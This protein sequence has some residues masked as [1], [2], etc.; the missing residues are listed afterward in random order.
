MWAG[1][2]CHARCW[3]GRTPPGR[4]QPRAASEQSPG[5]RR[6]SLLAAASPSM[7]APPSARIAS[8]V[9]TTRRRLELSGRAVDRLLLRDRSGRVVA[10]PRAIAVDGATSRRTVLSE[11]ESGRA[12]GATPR[13]ATAPMQYLC[14]ASD[15]RRLPALMLLVRC[16]R[17]P[18]ATGNAC[19]CLPSGGAAPC[20]PAPRRAALIRSKREWP[21]RGARASA[22]RA[23]RWRRRRFVR[24]RRQSAWTSR[25]G[26]WE[27]R[28]GALRRSGR[29]SSTHP[30]GGTVCVQR[31]E[32]RSLSRRQSD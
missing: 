23:G 30:E 27:T 8:P 32:R 19:C 13:G 26:L 6:A 2:R 17:V 29:Q 25:V 7:R 4:D 31:L 20:G 24:A 3:V 18:G 21:H 28:W 1:G 11:R 16:E 9:W 10:A 14:R 5:A 22:R 12:Q 15:D